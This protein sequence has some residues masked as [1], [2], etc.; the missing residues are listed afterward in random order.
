MIITNEI[1]IRVVA[2]TVN[3]WRQ[4]GYKCEVME[5]I[6]V[7]VNDLP[8]A[9]REI[10]ECSCDYC[11]KIQKIGFNV[12]KKSIKSN[13]KKSCNICKQNKIEETNLIK[14]GVKRPIQNS[15][16]RNKAVATHIKNHGKSTISQTKTGIDNIVNKLKSNYITKISKLN[17]GKFK[18][19]SNFGYEMT[20][21]ICNK[22][23]YIDYA[24][25]TRISR[26]IIPCTNC[27]P[28]N[29][30][31]AEID[32]VE[33]ISSLCDTE[34]ILNS[35][36][37]INPFELDIYLPEYN[38]AIEY[39]GIYWHSDVYKDQKYHLN[40]T[41][42]CKKQNIQLLH[43]WEDDWI[44]RPNIIKSIIKNKLKKNNT[45]FNAR[46]CYIKEISNK[47]AKPFF[48]KYH[49][50]GHRNAKIT[51]AL[52]EKSTDIM[53]AAM[54][55]NKKIGTFIKHTKNECIPEL[56]RFVTNDSNVRGG[57][58]K[59][60]K[61]AITTNNFTNVISYVDYSIFDGSSYIKNGFTFVSK[62]TPGYSYI[63]N[64]DRQHRYK[65][66]KDILVKNGFDPSLSEREI[67]KSLGFNRIYDCGQLK[68]V[69]NVS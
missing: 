1:K 67:M 46:S 23:Y 18:R 59:L 29:K 28:K 21:N 44:N 33:Y 25:M 48:D 68:L 27:L 38:F 24:I 45:I 17:I 8:D 9:C 16:I 35:R 12:Y 4:L 43:V 37:I 6:T 51:Y 66:R 64:N 56:I 50:Q 22:P 49:I 52:F 10:I 40:K 54:S 31:K 69:Y 26:N 63:I 42:E 62:S 20:C 11:G 61:Y 30:T 2:R 13:G 60:F 32:I 15:D 3:R 47:I 5:I 14:Y 7:K 55:F 39:N 53:V 19:I 34:I 36:K 65:Y 58:S 41:D 57:F